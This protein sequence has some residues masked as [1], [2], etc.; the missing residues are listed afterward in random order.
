M[1]AADF[2]TRVRKQSAFV[3]QSSVVK[4]KNLINVR[5]NGTMVLASSVSHQIGENARAFHN[6]M[7]VF[8]CVKDSASN[9]EPCDID[10][11]NLNPELEA[12]IEEKNLSQVNVASG[13]NSSE[14]YADEA[15]SSIGSELIDDSLSN[16]QNDLIETNIKTEVRGVGEQYLDS[17]QTDSDT[18]GSETVSGAQFEGNKIGGRVHSENLETVHMANVEDTL[19]EELFEEDDDDDDNADDDDKL[20]YDIHI[21]EIAER[22]ADQTDI[23]K[24]ENAPAYAP[25]RQGKTVFPKLYS[26]APLVNHSETL[27]SLVRLGVDLT[28]IEKKGLA[29]KIVKMDFKKYIKPH[30]FVLHELGV[31][32]EDLGKILSKDPQLFLEDAQNVKVRIQYLK[33]KKF[34][35]EEICNMVCS[36]SLF[37][38]M[39]SERIDTKLGIY[40]KLFQLT[41]SELRRAIIHCP[42]SLTYHPDT[43]KIAKL[44]LVNLMG[45]SELQVKQMFILDPKLFNNLQDNVFHNVE[46]TFERLYK[47]M[48]IPHSLIAKFPQILRSDGLKLA[49]RHRFLL[50]L[51]RAQYNPT[52]ENYVPLKD[53]IESKEADFCVNIAKASVKEYYKFLK[54]I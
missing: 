49:E 50:K 1:K 32:D 17:I 19:E 18:F 10:T 21:Q 51:G 20:M 48:E 44:K 45:F 7:H 15:L 35:R 25:D 13:E 4:E 31:P 54:T 37:L 33:S 6:S 22:K 39:T 30:V 47:T 3:G 12:K 38:R 36:N 34:K 14:N 43:V 46:D 5:P 27:S 2:Q 29:N 23:T 52:K 8:F 9:S 16:Y 41:G 53:L 42:K 11:P 28:A 40:Q 26:F 24:A